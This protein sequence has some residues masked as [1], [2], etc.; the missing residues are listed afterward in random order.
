MAP[1][2]G[3]GVRTHAR[4]TTETELYFTKTVCHVDVMLHVPEDNSS[5][6][7]RVIVRNAL[8]WL[9]SNLPVFGRKIPLD[10]VQGDGKC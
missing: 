7:E 10:S 4:S 5:C 2:M 3:R 9:K 1:L 6:S 8:G